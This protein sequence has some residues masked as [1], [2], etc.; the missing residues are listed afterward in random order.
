[1]C[2]PPLPINS[3]SVFPPSIPIP[4]SPASP[5]LQDPEPIILNLGIIN[6][7]GEE[8][9]EKT[10]NSEIDNVVV[11]VVLGDSEN[12]DGP[13]VKRIKLDTPPTS[14]VLQPK[15]LTPP[16][17]QPAAETQHGSE[18]SSDQST[19]HPEDPASIGHEKDDNALSNY[20]L[21][22]DQLRTGTLKPEAMDEKDRW[23]AYRVIVDQE[24]GEA[25]SAITK[26]P[27]QMPPIASHEKAI[28]HSQDSMVVDS[29]TVH[30]PELKWSKPKL[31]LSFSRR[32]AVSSQYAKR[33]FIFLPNETFIL[34]PSN[35]FV[36]HTISVIASQP[37]LTECSEI[38]IEL[39]DRE[40]SGSLS[41]GYQGLLRTGKGGPAK[42]V[43][44]KITCP[45][46]F[47]LLHPRFTHASA[48]KQVLK[49][50][51]NYMSGLACLQGEV[52]PTFYGLWQMERQLSFR[53]KDGKR[54]QTAFSLFAAVLEDVGTDVKQYA[55][56]TS[57]SQIPLL[58]RMDI[59]TLYA[60]LH[61]R[62]ILHHAYKPVHVRVS[63]NGQL[64]LIDF[65]K[66]DVVDDREGTV[67]VPGFYEM[68]EVK[69]FL[70]LNQS[71]IKEVLEKM[72]G[73]KGMTYQG[74]R[75]GTIRKWD[76]EAKGFTAGSYP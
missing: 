12:V 31:R 8:K 37:Y 7:L 51:T 71:H 36:P 27:S 43:I 38:M 74:C 64:R 52:V 50:T 67:G 28:V 63:P 41:D 33:Q 17:A 56:C 13:H 34:R 59:L 1:M 21:L 44:V 30:P 2:E 32:A 48:R 35:Y 54:H 22:A 3:E 69:T 14:D 57:S 4:T 39:L 16:P 62:C 29:E 49:E 76:P 70:S 6:P 75:F 58:L 45:G 9:Q 15:R 65:E 20:E 46:A 42:K 24:L 55:N 23:K 47:D 72:D 61:E 68:D 53:M 25:K 11:E 19:I 18:P 26:S 40:G 10:L 5:H 73:G 60:K 66:S